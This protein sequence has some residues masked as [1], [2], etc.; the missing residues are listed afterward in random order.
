MTTCYTAIGQ[1]GT[2]QTQVRSKRLRTK[3]KGKFYFY[4]G[5]NVSQYSKS[6]IHFEGENYDFTIHNAKAHDKVTKPI[7]YDKYLNPA[8]LTIPQTNARI[9]YYFHDN[10]NASIGLDHMK[11]VME[12]YQTARISGDIYLT[13][14]N[15]G[16]TYFNGTYNQQEQV[17]YEDF[18]AFEHTDG[19]NYVN[20]EIARV[21]NLGDFFGWNP[22]KIQLNITEGFSAGVLI[23]KTNAKVLNKDRY[24]QFH[25]SG[26]GVSLKAGINVTFFKYFF[27]QAELKGG[28]I[29]MP[30]IRTTS[31]KADSA[32]QHFNFLQ[33]NITFGGI[34]KV[35]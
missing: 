15:E 2:A 4:W 8:N 19:L 10:W 34:F 11:Y 23:P 20:L 9:G 22:D 12:Q 25:L 18:V 7:G 28:F 21:D 16:T 3:N 17:L 14:D 33:Q 27:L 35:F 29:D 31:S 32:K 5:W 13:E 1:T 6:N 24:D 26:Y 30:N